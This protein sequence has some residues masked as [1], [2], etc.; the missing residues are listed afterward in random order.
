MASA[1]VVVVVVVVYILHHTESRFSASVHKGIL[2]LK[3]KEMYTTS[4]EVYNPAFRRF[5]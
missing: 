4:R 1:S 5:E 3:G 2:G